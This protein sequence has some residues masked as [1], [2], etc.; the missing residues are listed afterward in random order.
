MMQVGRLV[1]IGGMVFQ[2]VFGGV[3]YA[4]THPC[5][6]E[7]NV[8]HAGKRS[9]TSY[10]NP[11]LGTATLWDQKDLQ[12]ERKRKSRTW[13][14]ETFPGAALP[15]AMVQCSPVTMYHSGSGYQ[16]EDSLIYG[17]SHTNKG[18]WNLLHIPVLPVCGH[19]WTADDYAS[20]FQHVK[21]EAHPGYYRVSLDRYGIQAELTTT[22]RCALHHYIYPK[23][24]E[25]NVI[26]DLPNANNN[27]HDWQIQQVDETHFY[28]YQN[29]DEKMY[30][31]GV[32]NVPM[33]EI[34]IVQGRHHVV[35]V[36]AFEKG[37]EKNVLL[38]MGFSFT[39]VEGAHRNLLAEVGDKGFQEVREEADK[40][41]ETLLSRIQVEGGTER[42]KGLF[43][44]CLYRAMLW[45]ALRSDVNYDY[46][47]VKGVVIHSGEVNGKKH[48][49]YTLPSFWD[50]Y[51]NKLVLLGW[52]MPE[53]TSDVI[54]SCID[55]GEKGR[56]YMPTFFHGDHA[57]TFI[58]GSWLRG[59]RNFSLERAYRLLLKNATVPGVGGR[60]YLDEYLR[61]GWI[62]EKDT[63][64][65]PYYDE[66]KA[67]VTKTLEYAYDDYATALVA[68]LLGDKRNERILMKHSKNYRNVFDSSTGFFRGR[69][70]DG[71]FVR[72][73]D[74][75]YPYFAYQFRESNAW[76]NLFFAPHDPMGIVRMYPSKREVEKKLDSLFTE[77]W[78]G[79][80][81]E[82]LTGFIGNY[83][84]GNQPGHSIPYM[85]YFVGKQEKCQAILNQ[86]M[87]TLYDMGEEHLAL[88]GMDDAGE[89]SSWYV[90]NAMGL[91][92]YS[93]ADQKYLLTVPLF[94]NVSITLDNGNTFRIRRIGDGT[95]IS[96]LIYGGKT[97]KGWFLS[98]SM[99]AEGK[100]LVVHTEDGKANK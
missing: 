70:A 25:K 32:T 64:N 55:R 54:N 58:S 57:S 99:L 6:Y 85:Y 21:E 34:K 27:V 48:H 60:S 44:S 89:M 42:Q 84:H 43:Y 56:G 100:E 63:D 62:A 93:P 26:F 1:A 98:H 87:E 81:V 46:T 16:Y 17:F 36:I 33:K 79:Y 76:N 52:L 69:I 67:A 94:R 68:R 39:S 49:Y 96:S 80:E 82:N 30:F 65:V 73:F 40:T 75:Y 86:I 77:P 8:A 78:R 92:T 61:Q 74:P 3:V 59:I 10:V 91:Y 71:S 12:Y 7:K 9:L 97:L 4:E 95:R 15:C 90:F 35:A 5:S 53:V 38:K 72:Q 24:A 31:W 13:G 22:P 37:E 50:D 23:S 19:K 11:F 18:H 2:T 88:A 29:V 14:G 66:Y 41:W 20:S 28:G 47:D 51:R 83:C 45:P